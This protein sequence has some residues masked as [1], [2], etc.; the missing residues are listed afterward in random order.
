VESVDGVASGVNRLRPKI[1]LMS[2]INQAWSLPYP[3]EFFSFSLQHH[4]VEV[5]REKRTML[6]AIVLKKS[7]NLKVLELRSIVAYNFLDSQSELILSPS[8]EFL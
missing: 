3:K 5:C 8:Q 1:D 4:F 6:D 7:I 2:C